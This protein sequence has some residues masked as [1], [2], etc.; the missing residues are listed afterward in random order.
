MIKEFCDKCGR[1]VGIEIFHGNN[2]I[3]EWKAY[4][5]VIEGICRVFC[6]VCH[7]DYQKTIAP[8]LYGNTV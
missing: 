4:R 5:P 3:D 6:V 7:R 1:Q 2:K 8:F